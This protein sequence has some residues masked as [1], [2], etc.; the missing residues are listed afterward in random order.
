[1]VSDPKKAFNKDYLSKFFTSSLDKRRS[2]K[3]NF[4]HKF[5][6][7]LLVSL[8][9]ALCGI[10]DY[11]HMVLFAEQ[12]IDWFREHGDFAHGA[13]S[14]ET[15]RR[16]FVALDPIGFEECFCS[17]ASSLY[18]ETDGIDG[19]VVAVDGKTIRGARDK[20]DP[21][22]LSPHILT[23]WA[24]DQGL[25][26]GQLKVKEKSNEITA[27]PELLKKI[28]IK[29]ST[30]TIDA[31][32]CQQNIVS[33]IVAEKAHYI[34]AVKDNQK[35]LALAIK[36]T[37]RLERPLEVHTH[38]EVGHGRVVTKT[39]SVYGELSHLAEISKWKD[40]KRFVVVESETYHK[41]SKKTTKETRAYI[42]DL[43]D[44]AESFNQKIQRHWAIENELHWV[45]DVCFNEDASRKRVAN[46]AQNM[47]LVMKMALSIL[48]RN[49]EKPRE[50]YKSQRLK[51][52]LDRKY[53]DKL[54]K[55]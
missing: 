27:I 41:A 52:L 14:D 31:M 47:N 49:K 25:S 16:L 9:S 7:I 17:W 22:S 21:S 51:A 11:K 35:E 45:L 26:L 42:S 30:V 53:R 1:M 5:H 44:S 18:V 15:I 54:I 36:D 20:N 46:T 29:G 12:E 32:G 48:K 23:A 6:D 55:S 39:C 37:H 43:L 10:E 8:A 24:T 28:H 2:G 40:L 50:S 34:I 19:E 13:P 3:G 33:A 38:N 4:R